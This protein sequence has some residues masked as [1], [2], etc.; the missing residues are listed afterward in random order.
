MITGQIE[1][2]ESLFHYEDGKSAANYAH[3]GF[4]PIFNPCNSTKDEEEARKKCG[5]NTDCIFDFCTTRDEKLAT[6]TK[7]TEEVF[8]Q[9]KKEDGI[10]LEMIMVAF[11]FKMTKLNLGFYKGILIRY[12]PLT[13]VSLIF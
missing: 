1:S 10:D 4:V 7:L 12:N 6:D 8:E 3:P 5:D 9:D 13:Y 11:F 2:G